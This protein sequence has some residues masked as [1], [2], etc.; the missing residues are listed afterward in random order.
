M[1]PQLKLTGSRIFES[2]I[3]LDSHFHLALEASL[4]IPKRGGPSLSEY[5]GLVVLGIRAIN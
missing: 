4:P 2:S 5:D 1:V 3:E